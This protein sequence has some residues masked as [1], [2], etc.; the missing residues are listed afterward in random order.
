MA[1]C[2]VNIA[3]EAQL[4]GSWDYESMTNLKDGKPFG[5][6]H[7]KP[8][9]WTITFKADG[10]CNRSGLGKNA[11]P[12]TCTYKV[13]KKELAIEFANGKKWDYKFEIHDGKSLRMTDKNTIFEATRRLILLGRPAQPL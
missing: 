12:Q 13:H 11:E 5:T 2:T 8:G 3:Q 10:T 9:Q 1:C 7:F 4:V 6:V